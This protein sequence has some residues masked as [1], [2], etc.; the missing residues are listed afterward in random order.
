MNMPNHGVIMRQLSGFTL[1]LAAPVLLAQAAPEAQPG[2]FQVQ[3]GLI[4]QNNAK[5]L[6]DAPALGAGLGRWLAPAF[7]LEADVLT[8]RIEDRAHLWTAREIHGDVAALCDPFAL[9][10]AC[11]PFLRAGI[12]GTRVQ[13]PL[14]LAPADTTRLNLLGGLGV[15]IRWAQHGLL[16]LEERAISVD[17][18]TSRREFQSLLGFGFRWGGHAAPAT[19]TDGQSHRP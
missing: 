1:L 7:G 10:G 17:S 14:S 6:R 12:G 8:A 4:S 18:A 15:Q 2:W 9:E 13:A 19:G 11:K 3:A 5:C 16:T